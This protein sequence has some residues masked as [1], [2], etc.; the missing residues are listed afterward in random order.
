MTPPLRVVCPLTR[1]CSAET[2]W[3]GDLPC[4]VMVWP[5]MP[6]N[7]LRGTRQRRGTSA[8]SSRRSMPSVRS[9]PRARQHKYSG[10][11]TRCGWSDPAPWAPTA[12]KP[13]SHPERWSARLVRTPTAARLVTDSSASSRES[14]LCA[15]TRPPWP[16]CVPG[17]HRT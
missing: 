14:T 16:T 11:E 8:S 7:S 5:W 13:G 17:L 15:G 12:P 2:P 10:W 3:V 6:R 1:F 4:R 9:P